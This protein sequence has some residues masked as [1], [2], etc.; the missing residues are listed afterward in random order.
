MLVYAMTQE[1]QLGNAK[2]ALSGVQDDAVFLEAEEQLKKM[3][4]MLLAVF[5]GN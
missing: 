5:T 3:E 4:F 1:I 2:F